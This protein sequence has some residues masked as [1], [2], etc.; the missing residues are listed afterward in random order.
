VGRYL[1]EEVAHYVTVRKASQRQ[2][3]LVIDEFSAI[4][5]AADAANL[6]ERI[7]SYGASV[8]VSSQSY[9]GLGP[10]A[11]RLLGAA[12]TLILHRCS[13]PERL[14]RL[15]G[16]VPRYEYSYQTET[17]GPTGKV[18][19]RQ[20]E[21]HRVD[22]NAARQ[23]ETGESFIVAS[24]RAARVRITPLAIDDAAGMHLLRRGGLEPTIRQL[25]PRRP[26]PVPLPSAMPIVQVD[27]APTNLPPHT[28][29]ATAPADPEPGSDI[30]VV[31]ATPSD[32]ASAPGADDQDDLVTRF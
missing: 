16:T 10:E 32:R 17:Y 11:D 24:G 15:A 26:V 18:T 9:S 25:R 8:I 3:L 27:V 22:P 19:L 4:S 20:R 7:R 1:L 13:D 6:F 14:V 23:L 2:V 28:G 12:G 31:P 29:P 30:S 5:A 21:A